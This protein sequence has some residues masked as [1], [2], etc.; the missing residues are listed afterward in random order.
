MTVS[1]RVYVYARTVLG[2]RGSMLTLLGLAWAVNG[3]AV[4][5]RR[6]PDYLALLNAWEWPRAAMWVVTGVVAIVMARRREDRA[7]WVALYIMAAYRAL[8]YGV[9]AVTLVLGVDGPAG[10]HEVASAASRA[11][12]WV[13]VVAAIR[14]CSGWR[15]HRED[16]AT[17]EIPVSP[18]AQ[19]GGAT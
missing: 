14:I 13:A 8:A 17:G 16:L 19:D 1:R 9:G 3:L 2:R 6:E 18:A 10:L 4:P 12:T 5:F 7:G 11:A 15:E